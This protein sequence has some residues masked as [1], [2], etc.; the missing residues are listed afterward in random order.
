MPLSLAEEV[1]D[2]PRSPAAREG[3]PGPLGPALQMDLPMG[4][5]GDISD[6]DPLSVS[7]PLRNHTRRWENQRRRPQ[8]GRDPKS[9]V[10][11]RGNQTPPD[12]MGEADA[13]LC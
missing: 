11:R 2:S 3:P 6:S 10:K 7:C 5:S 9:P 13:G 4:L 8:G 12:P 1:S